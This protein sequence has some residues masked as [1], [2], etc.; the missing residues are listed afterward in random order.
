[1]EEEKINLHPKPAVDLADLPAI[2]MAVVAQGPYMTA[3]QAV[4]SPIWKHVHFGITI[5]KAN[6]LE[7]RTFV[8]SLDLSLQIPAA[9]RL[10]S[11]AGSNED[12]A[13]ANLEE[14]LLELLWVAR[15]KLRMELDKKAEANKNL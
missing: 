8:E 7:I 4:A 9:T 10:A 6:T 14:T 15:Y 12:R 5:D 11:Y 13:I 1:M 3:A 2:D